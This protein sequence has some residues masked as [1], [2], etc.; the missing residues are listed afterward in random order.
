MR[1]AAVVLASVP[2]A[3]ASLTVLLSAQGPPP[4]RGVSTLYAQLCANCHGLA[5]AGGQAPSLLDD[6][7][8]H[9]GDDTSL[10]ASIR[11]GRL[12]AGMPAFKGALTEEE[13]RAFV[14]YIREMADKARRDRSTFAKPVANVVVRSEQHAFRLETIAGGLETPW[15]IAFLPDGRLLVTERPGRLRVIGDGRLDPTPIAGLPPV[16]LKQDGGLLDLGIHP[17]YTKNGWIYLAFSEAGREPESS[18]TK[19]IRGR[20]REGNLVDQEVLFEA[21]PALFWIDNTHFGARFLFD[22]N[23]HVFYSIGDRGRDRLAQD[24]SSP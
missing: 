20:I 17:D 3:I 5:L 14:I 22:R 13:I 12:A 19:I 10:M 8:S 4:P 9:G 11:E 2:L 21:P 6:T 1:A 7:W 23:G 24:L 16:W 18:T 15:G